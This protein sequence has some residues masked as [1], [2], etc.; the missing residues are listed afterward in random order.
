MRIGMIIH[1]Y[2]RDVAGGAE[3]ACREVAVRLA[4]QG[5]EVHVITSCARSY[6]DWADELAPGPSLDDGVHVQRLP[7]VHRRDPQRFADL[8][9]RV[10]GSRHG[11]PAHLQREWMDAQGPVLTGLDDAIVGLGADVVVIWTYLYA[12]TAQAMQTCHR[13][14]IATV[15][16]PT[17]HDEPTVRLPIVRQA[18][19]DADGLALLTP[20][21]RDLVASITGLDRPAAIV[22]LGLDPVSADAGARAA[23]RSVAGDRPFALCVGRIDP[24]KGTM[25]LAATIGD[26]TSRHP[27]TPGLVLVGDPAHRIDLPAGVTQLGVVDERLKAGLLAEAV[28]LVQPSPYESFSIVL[29]EA[30]AQYTPVVVSAA[31]EVTS[32]QVRRSGGGVVFADGPDLVAAIEVLAEHPDLRGRL[33]SRGHSYLVDHYRWD[34]VMDRW[35]GLLVEVAGSHRARSSR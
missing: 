19:A 11:A 28:C 13:A 26:H 29:L 14:G 25:A 7:V 27:D 34:R 10:V 30:W 3:T 23:A 31:C 1:R 32:G 16:V 4:A 22:G 9:D 15:L 18:F 17:A 12:T 5:H 35:Q 20:E 8:S 24:S 21:E 2:G 33:G 6:V